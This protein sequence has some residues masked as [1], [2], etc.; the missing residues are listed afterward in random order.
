[1]PMNRDVAKLLAALLATVLA[2]YGFPRMGLPVFINQVLFLLLTLYVVRSPDDLFW[3]VWFFVVNDAPGRL[4]IG[5][6][7]LGQYRLPVYTIMPAVSITFEEI[8]LLTFSIKSLIKRA[9]Y[10]YMFARLIWLYIAVGFIYFGISFGLGMSFA[11]IISTVRSLLPWF[12]LLILPRYLKNSED[13][14]RVY[15]M[16]VP[17]MAIAFVTLIQAYLTGTYL[18]NILGGASYQQMALATEEHLSRA[19]S[20][21]SIVFLGITLSLYFLAAKRSRL[22]TNM[23]A[24]MAF[25][26]TFSVFISGTR[27]WLIALVILYFSYFFISGFSFFRQ[28]ARMMVIVGLMLIGLLNLFPVLNTQSVLAI[29]RYQTLEL[30][31]EGDLGAGGTLSRL[32]DI[33]P[34]VMGVFRQ[35]PIIGWAFSS[36]FWQNANVHVGNQTNLL[37]LGVLGFTLINWIYL[38]IMLKIISYGRNPE[39]RANNG[40][41][42]MVLLFGM[43]ALFAIHSSSGIWWGYYAAGTSLFWAFFLAAV[44]AELRV[45][46][47]DNAL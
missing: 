25:L 46:R 34:R 43:I 29:E 20:A 47:Q 8:F 30:L 38:A 35:S 24:A 17:I 13:L 26:G 2:V 42:H 1:M 45:F 41:A 22:N 14:K 39:Y 44:N 27:G 32:T 6:G 12:W 15:A 23:L 36:T 3:L 31:A 11:N 10:T 16:I 5:S 19:S 4:L 9:A 40:N 33:G 37:N 7:T 18:H 28:L 21:E